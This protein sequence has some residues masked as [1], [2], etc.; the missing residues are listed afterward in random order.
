MRALPRWSISFA[1]LALLLL[2]FFVLL[3]A[4]DRQQV[5][6]GARAAFGDVPI[7]G[8]LLDETAA[9]LFE[10]GEARLTVAARLRILDLAR[11]AGA[12][13]LTV[14]SNGRDAAASRFDA[15]ELAAARTAAL[16][17]AL[18]EAGVPEERITI[19]VGEG[20]DGQT[21]QRLVIR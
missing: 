4:G 16:A 2:C 17:R 14:H 10:P 9:R 11:S 20:D 3:Q 18:K 21:E 1:D 13:P 5:A 7:R 12:S 19:L 8:P 6:A 15:W